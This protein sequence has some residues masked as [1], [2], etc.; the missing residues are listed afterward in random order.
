[1]TPEDWE[2]LQAAFEKALAM[3]DGAERAAYVAELHAADPAFAA[4]LQQML[5]ADNTRDEELVAPVKAVAASLG[6]SAKDR[7]VGTTLGNYRLVRRIAVGGM[8]AVYLGQRSDEQFEQDVAIKIVGGHIPSEDLLTRFRTERQILASLNHPNIAQLFDGGATEDG[9][10]YIVMEHIDG[11]PIDEYCDKNVLAIKD[12][13]ALFMKVCTAVDYAHRNLIVHRDI[14]P[15]NILVTRDGTPKLLDFGIAKPLESAQLSQTIAVTHASTRAMTPE[16]ASPEQV[17]GE[18]IT[19][20]T[21]VYSLG[22]LLYKLLSGRMPYLLKDSGI[23]SFARAILESQPSRPSTAIALADEAKDQAPAIVAKR[24][25]TTTG[26]KKLLAGDL[27]NITLATLHKEPE[28]RY[29]S[30]RALADDIARFLANEPVTARPDSV[31]YR[32]HKFVRRN[33]LGVGAA[34]AVTVT[35]IGLVSFYTWQVTQERDRAELEARK[36]TQVVD[37]L[38]GIFHSSSPFYTGGEEPTIREVLAT[39][40]GQLESELAEQPEILAELLN[41]LGK[42]YQDIG[43]FDEALP[44]FERS[45]EIGRQTWGEHDVR[46][47]PAFLNIGSAKRDQYDLEAALQIAEEGLAIAEATTPR[48]PFWEAGAWHLIGNIQTDIGNYAAAVD[49]NRTAVE[50][51]R[52]LL[53]QTAEQYAIVLHDLAA[54]ISY[55]GDLEQSLELAEEAY[56]LKLAAFGR[57]HPT[58]AVSLLLQSSLQG[59]LG[60]SARSEALLREALAL[61]EQLFGR[62]HPEF[63]ITLVKMAQFF[64]TKQR[65]DDEEPLLDEALAIFESSFGDD[66]YWTVTTRSLLAE[67]YSET[68]RTEEALVF[69]EEHLEASRSQFGEESWD[70]AMAYSEYADVLLEAYRDDEAIAS[71]RRSVAAWDALNARVNRSYTQSKLGR[72]LLLTGDVVAATPEIT[73]ALSTARAEAPPQHSIMARVLVAHGE[74]LVAQG[75]LAGARAAANEA[76]EIFVANQEEGN[77]WYWAARNIIA[78]ALLVEEKE[79]EAKMELEAIVNGL[80]R[81]NGTRSRAEDS[82]RELLDN[83]G[84]GV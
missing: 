6:E 36:A 43:A 52:S 69:A 71:Y 32:L 18:S 46:I 28:R 24:G 72:A 53:P 4:E 25:T 23:D 63:A 66:H 29:P 56:A 77:G 81:D 10:P 60:N 16:Y 73:A 74:L 55:T 80:Q 54:S 13:L 17:R 9:M 51:F 70:A 58:V 20:A 7:W 15:S 82:A 3:K 19:T 78:T 14:K 61:R 67:V 39:G 76:L 62:D 8:S 65:W 44:L 34:A 68:G 35:I 45:L 1:M 42:I 84:E 37:F 64:S 21:D 48:D 12:R 83:T 22:V 59:A 40:A 57:E 2:T 50:K 49:A 26:L 30:A 31:A 5:D 79:D 47:L 11:L 33:R 38:S 41:R 27:D 75:D